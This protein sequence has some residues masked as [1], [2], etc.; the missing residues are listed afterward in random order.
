MSFD[1][2]V[3]KFVIGR[4]LVGVSSRDVQ[5]IFGISGGSDCITLIDFL[6]MIDVMLIIVIFLHFLSEIQM[7]HHISDAI[8]NFIE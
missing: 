1:K 5:L 4:E 7:V 3:G 2:D 6:E 8:D